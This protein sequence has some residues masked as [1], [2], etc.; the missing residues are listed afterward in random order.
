VAKAIVRFD[1]ANERANQQIETYAGEKITAITTDTEAAA[2]TAILAGYEQGQGPIQIA[3]DLAG[4]IGPSGNREGGVL[5]MSNAQTEWAMSF[6]QRLLSGDPTQMREALGMTL[7]DKRYDKTVLNAIE[8]G[9]A[10][11][12]QDVTRMVNRYIDNAVKLRGETVARTET[13]AAVHKA[14][15][16]AFLQT[17]NQTEYTP[18]D[19]S[20]TWRSA[21]DKKVRDT[22][23]GMNGQTV[24]GLHT[25][26]V[27]PS[28]AR[29]MHPLDASLGAPASE[30]VNCRCDE[31]INIDFAAPLRR[32]ARRPKVPFEDEE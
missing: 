20:R 9:E 31:E 4:R 13:G 22:H 26:F 12:T 30:I 5:G 8:T 32:M 11:P 17:L 7:R 2:R 23:R 18:D 6:R 21:G 19:V 27:S 15:H 24:D 10:L 3:L 28:G 14:A 25:P 16:E 29:L 1:V